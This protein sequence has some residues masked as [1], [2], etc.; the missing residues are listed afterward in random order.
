MKYIFQYTKEDF[1]AT[2]KTTKQKFYGKLDFFL[3]STLTYLNKDILS[4]GPK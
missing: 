4:I 1:T 2:N 3:K